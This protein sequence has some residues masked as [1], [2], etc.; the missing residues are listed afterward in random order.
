MKQQIVSI[1]EKLC[2]LLPVILLG[3]F[4][5]FIRTLAGKIRGE[6]YRWSIAVSR[7]F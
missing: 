7:R 1:F 5:G 2:D 3:G 4:G 6:H